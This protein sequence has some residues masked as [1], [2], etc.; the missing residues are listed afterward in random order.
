M[1]TASGISSRAAWR[2][3]T[4][5]RKAVDVLRRA[6]LERLFRVGFLESGEAPPLSED[7]AEDEA[8]A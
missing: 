5:S 8:S 7:G 2:T 3:R 6:S 4:S 1:T